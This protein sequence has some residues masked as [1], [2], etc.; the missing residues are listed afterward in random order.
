[1]IKKIGAL[2]IVSICIIFSP[3]FVSAEKKQN[4]NQNQIQTQN[5][6]EEQELQIE[7][8]EEEKSGTDQGQIKNSSSRSEKAYE[9]MSNV[10]EKV[11]ELLMTKEA[12]E[13]IGQQIREV[14]R[15]QNE[16][17][18]KITKELEKLDLKQGFMKKLFGPD[19]KTIKNLNKE[20]E[21]NQLRIQQL[22]QLETQL[23]NQEDLTNLQETID[24]LI[25]ENVSL[26]ERVNFEEGT[27][28]LFGWLFKLFNK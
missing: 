14:A 22:E 20:I 16:A 2:L 3:L 24:A 6:G 13:G 4:Q 19:Y 1:M 12:N 9:H 28:S 23:T 18:K 11:Q 7:N 25:Q 27:K 17:Q 21:Q 26:K 5:Q 8:Q 10:A 15:T